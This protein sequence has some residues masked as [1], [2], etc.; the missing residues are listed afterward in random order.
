ILVTAGTVGSGYNDVTIVVVDSEV[1]SLP[2]AVYTLATKTLTITAQL[3]DSINSLASTRDEIIT[4]IDDTIFDAS[5]Y[6]LIGRYDDDVDLAVY[7]GGDDYQI[8]GDENGT[9]TNLYYYDADL[10]GDYTAGEDIWVDAIVVNGRFDAGEEIY[11]GGNAYQVSEDEVG[12]NTGLYFDNSASNTDGDNTYDANEDIWKDLLGTSGDV[13]IGESTLID[14]LTVYGE[15]ILVSGNVNATDAI[16]LV[17]RTDDVTLN[18]GDLTAGGAGATISIQALS[19]VLLTYTNLNAA[20]SISLAATYGEV[21]QPIGVGLISTSDLTVNAVKDISL[22][23]AVDTV[24]AAVSGLSGYGIILAETDAITLTSLSTVAGAITVTAGGTID[25]VSVD[26]SSNN[27]TYDITLTTT[28][29]N[30]AVGSVNA[31]TDNVILTAAGAIT[32]SLA[33]ADVDITG[34]T[35]TL[36]AVAGIGGLAIPDDDDLDISA[37]T[38]SAE[39]SG[40]TGDIVITRTAGDIAVTKLSQSSDTGTGSILFVAES[41]SITIGTDGMSVAGSGY[42][43]VKASA[44]V[45]Q[46]ADITTTDGYVYVD[47]QAGAISMAGGTKSETASGNILYQASGLIDIATLSSNSG[48]SISI[49]A[50]G[51]VNLNTGVNTT[52]GTVDIQAG[53]SGPG[54]LNMAASAQILTEGVNIRLAAVDSITIG[55]IDTRTQVDRFGATLLEQNTWGNVS[56]ATNNGAITDAGAVADDVDVYAGEL[57]MSAATSIGKLETEVYKVAAAS[58]SGVNLA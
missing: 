55:Q 46:N 36:N 3:T 2:T 58:A 23:T 32:D 8:D 7:D 56:I 57:R 41:G 35:V 4:A 14:K 26:T 37:V 1:G 22:N 28:S 20:D 27:G 48:G 21:N 6:D 18:G 29:G 54:G 9:Q 5:E 25:A 38:V 40:D 15:S 50:G 10:S 24:N 12:I 13:E 34:T 42:V 33:D 30:I 31:G 49:L 19:D 47:A 52:S 39:N 53:I 16:E 17:A 44:S 43:V 51:T 45:L 11:D